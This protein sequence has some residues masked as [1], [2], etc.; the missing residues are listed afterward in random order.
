MRDGTSKDPSS[1]TPSTTT[2]TTTIPKPYSVLFHPYL[3]WTDA[4]LSYFLSYFVNVSV[5]NK[6]DPQSNAA[7]EELNKIRKQLKDGAEGS[8]GRI[9]LKRW[10]NACNCLLAEYVGEIRFQ[11]NILRDWKIYDDAGDLFP[12]TVSNRDKVKVLVRFPSSLMT[13]EERNKATVLDYSG[14]LKVE[15]LDLKTFVPNVPVL[16]QFHGGGL[17]VGDCHKVELIND[18]ANLV[19]TFAEEHIVTAPD[20]I[21]I[22]ID[23]GLAPEDRF[24]VA[25]I[26]ALSVIDYLLADSPTRKLHLSGE[27]AGANTALVA[28]LECVRKY[29]GRIQSAQ[30]QCPMIDPAGETMSYY[31]NQHVFPDM[32]W[33]RWCW[34]AYLGL[35]APN[36]TDNPKT[37]EEALRKDSN[38]FT[39]RDWKEKYP[40]ALQR[41]INPACDIPNQVS[42]QDGPKLFFRVNMGDPLFDE[43]KEIAIALEDAR[44]HVALFELG[45]IHCS[46]GGS[47]N[48]KAHWEFMKLWANAIFASK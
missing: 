17:T 31:M 28:C 24:P 7:E 4:F 20:I 16:V 42:S 23:Y 44:A 22:S 41:L 40:V 36:K 10:S 33:L 38:H 21:T 11:K 39:W 29:P 8:F 25:I 43:G 37:L 32:N 15:E 34:R 45:G 14:C 9:P 18:V 30:M 35:E 48:P 27:S 3:S 47:H 13:A 6:L 12:G 1:S 19:T 26:D 46:I 5:L 2:T